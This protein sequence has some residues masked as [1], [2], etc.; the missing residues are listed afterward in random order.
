M[1]VQCGISTKTRRKMKNMH[2]YPRLEQSMP[3]RF[4]PAT[5][6]RSARGF[7]IRLRIA[8]HDGCFTRIPS[9]HASPRGPEEVTEKVASYF[10]S[11]PVGVKTNTPLKQ[12]LGKPDTSGRLVKWAVELSEYDISYLPRTTIKAQ[13]L[14]D[15]V[16][17]MA[18][19]T[20]K[21][22]SQDQKW[23][24]HVDGSSTAQG[25]G[26]GIVIT[27][28]QGEDLEFSIKFDFK[29]SNNEAE[30]ENAKADCLSKLASSLED[31]RTRHITIHYLPKARTPL[32]VQPITRGE[33][34]RTPIINWIEEGLLSENRW[35]AARLKTRATRFIMQEHILYK[36]FYTHPLLR[37]L[38]TEEGIHILQEI[39][40]GC[41]GAHAGTRIL[42]NKP[43]GQDTSGQP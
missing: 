38:S 11:H 23:L 17:E 40:S 4:L 21:D 10:L 37:C 19:M 26:A 20:I 7:H 30:E 2:R 32:A 34:W 16:S 36:K 13:A 12:T 6:N 1:A 9:D 28:S 5:T 24:L 8:Q 43:F 42:A 25:S 41:C 15:F 31:C 27:T 3:Q 22:A 29:A 33:D 14:A 39:H 35:E 18:E